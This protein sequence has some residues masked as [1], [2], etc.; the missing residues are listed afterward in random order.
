[1]FKRIIDSIDNVV[2]VKTSNPDMF[3]LQEYIRIAE[4]KCSVFIG[5]DGLILAGL[6]AGVDGVVSGN[7]SAF[8]E[9]FVRVYHAF[10]RGEI[11]EA[12]DHQLF[13]YKLRNALGGGEIAWFKMALDF[14]GIKVGGVRE[15][16]RNL[17]AEEAA[18]LRE[19]LSELGLVD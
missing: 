18:R 1:V 9:P 19:S 12:K 14:R 17:S 10:V 5:D 16:H 7:S 6:S 15:P 4:D 13:I 3:Q 11:R 8:P 2:G